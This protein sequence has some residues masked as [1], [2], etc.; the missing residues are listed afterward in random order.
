MKGGQQGA[1]CEEFSE[2]EGQRA[3][4]P[5]RS[6]WAGRQGKEAGG[7]VLPSSGIS[8]NLGKCSASLLPLVYFSFYQAE[9]GS[10]KG[11]AAFCS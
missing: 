8:H 11:G 1:L 9:C 3:L 2:Q 5:E 10:F 7:R 4:G 6:H